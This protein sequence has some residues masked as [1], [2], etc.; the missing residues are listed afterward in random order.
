[1][2]R[3]EARRAVIDLE[4]YRG[5]FA[6]ARHVGQVLDEPAAVY[7]DG[8]EQ[9]AVVYVELAERLPAAVA[10]LR[11]IKYAS[12]P[13]TS[14]MLSTS[15]TIGYAP[16]LP[17]RFDETCR[18]AQLAADQ[19]REHAAIAGLAHVVERYYQ[20]FNADLY[21]EHERTVERVLPEW[22][23]DGG[24][25]TSGIVNYN[26]RLPYHFDRGNFPDVWSNMVVFRR[27]VSGGELVLPELDLAF[28]LADHSLF[29]FDG[30]GILHG[31]SPFRLVR[32]SGYR[33]SVV[34]YSLRQMWRCETRAES[35][36]LAQRRRTERERR[37]FT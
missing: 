24:V 18:S 4:R 23:L 10:A 6:D 3:V 28:R 7:V 8:A 17:L 13:R 30:Q 12:D 26:N 21:A 15:R 1:M 25:F 31:V 9:P 27:D 22:R 14:G 37:R 16:K 20:R 34:F 19:P 33:Y 29:M 2:R 36:G 11:S 35:V 5:A 32:P